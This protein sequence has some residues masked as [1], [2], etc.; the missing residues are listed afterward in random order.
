MSIFKNTYKLHHTYDKL[1]ELFDKVNA[2]RNFELDRLEEALLSSL[3]EDNGVATEMYSTLSARR[4]AWDLL[5][6]EVDACRY[7]FDREMDCRISAVTPLDRALCGEEIDGKECTSTYTR[8]NSLKEVIRQLN[9]VL[10]LLNS[11][12][13]QMKESAL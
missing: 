3:S 6:R 2:A 1:E 5:V 4:E 13:E 7:T 9:E 10:V 12:L 8:N 11:K